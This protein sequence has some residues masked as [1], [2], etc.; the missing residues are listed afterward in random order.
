MALV[1]VLL[2]IASCLGFGALLLKG[3]RLSSEFS[4]SEEAIFSFAIGFGV[5]GWLVFPLGI[6]GLLADGWL[7][8]LLLLGLPGLLILKIPTQINHCPD[9]VGWLLISLIGVAAV[10]DIAEALA[11]P[12]DAD[13]LAH[14]FN[15]PKL[16]LQ[17]GVIEFI[18]RPIDGSVPYLVQ[19]TYLPVLGL[20]GERALTLWTMVLIF[21]L[22]MYLFDSL[23]SGL[24][25]LSPVFAFWLILHGALSRF[26]SLVLALLG[27]ICFAGESSNG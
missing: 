21:L 19:M 20:G 26:S 27:C 16:F 6:A 13:T 5:L 8:G 3:L 17:A 7:L 12:G 2:Q 11:P 9:L 14:H 22:F 10:F 25:L 23:L 4:P 1:I 24:W 15:V 18:L